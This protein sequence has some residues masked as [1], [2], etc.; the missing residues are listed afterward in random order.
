MKRFVPFVLAL[1]APA[2]AGAQSSTWTMEPAHT[3]ATFVVRHLAITNV[4]GEFRNVSGTLQLDEKDVTRS[5]VEAKLDTASIDTRVA[6]RDKHLRSADF[7]DAEKN[8]SI[9]FR[10]TKVE[11]AG[12]GRL[13]VTGDLTM[14]GV[15]RPVVLD[16]EGPTAEVKDARG[17]PRRGF[18]ASTRISRKDFGIAWNRLVEAGPVVGDEVR[19]EI[20]GQ[21]VK[22]AGEK[23]AAN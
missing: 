17:N 4:R 15:T 22:Q 7:F 3:H 10:S 13:K 18:S 11:K 23:T 8:P 6:D 5:S 19:I 12:E 16:V 21:L 9:L 20:E 1:A 2:L 14:R